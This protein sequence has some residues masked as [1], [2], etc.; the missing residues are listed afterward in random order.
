ME[1]IWMGALTKPEVIAL[2]RNRGCTINNVH[3]LNKIMEEIGV[4]VRSES[5]WLIT[6]EAVKYTSS[7]S[8]VDEAIWYPSVV[9]AIYDFLTKQHM[10]KE[11]I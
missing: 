7:N 4:L 8:Q 10:V 11:G 6:E 1:F 3:E 9:D 2:L 5:Q